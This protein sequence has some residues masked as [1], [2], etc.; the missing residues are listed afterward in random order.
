MKINKTLISIV[1]LTAFVSVWLRTNSHAQA[2]KNPAATPFPGESL[3]L[4][5]ADGYKPI[6]VIEGVRL[7]GGCEWWVVQVTADDNSTRRLLI[8]PAQLR[9]IEGAKL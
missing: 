9:A 1:L 4:V 3:R 5:Y 6:A 2:S 7:V 8:N